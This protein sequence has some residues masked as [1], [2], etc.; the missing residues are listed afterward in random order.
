[1]LLPSP[2]HPHPSISS[3]SFHSHP[4]ISPSLFLSLSLSLPPNFNFNSLSRTL[5][6]TPCSS[7]PSPLNSSDPLAFSPYAD[8]IG[9][10]CCILGLG[11]KIGFWSKNSSLNLAFV[12]IASKSLMQVK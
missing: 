7:N 9:S 6:I 1:M 10:A 3:L 2:I 12:V 11:T 5:T 8:L 4:P